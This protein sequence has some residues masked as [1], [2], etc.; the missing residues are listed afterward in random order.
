MNN[1]LASL[2][3]IRKP[4]VVLGTL[5]ATLLVVSPRLAHCQAVDYGA[6]EQLFK[7]PVTTSVTGSPQR[8]SDV[9]ATMV[10]ITAEEIRRSGAKDIPGVLR[11]VGGIDTLEWGN[12]NIDV[13]IR[14]YNQAYSARLLVLLDGRQVYADTYGYVP[15]STIPVELE[16]IRQIEVVK[17]PNSALF[18][19]NAAGGV[20]NIITYDPLRDKV[21]AA[22][23]SGGTQDLGRGSLVTTARFGNR[24]GVRLSVGGRYDSDFSTPIPASMELEPRKQQYRGAIDLNAVIRMN[25]K[26]QLSFEGS[27]SFTQQNEVY[28]GYQ[29]NDVR[30]SISSAKGQ[31]TAENS[32]GLLRVMV[33]TNWLKMIGV[34]GALGQS[35]RPRNRATVV[36]VDEVFQ[37]GPSHTLRV[38]AEYRHNSENTTPFAGGTVYYDDFAGS[39]MWDW[40]IAPR[41]SLT[42]ALRVDHLALGRE[43]LLPP[44]YLFKNSDWNR[45]ITQLTFNSGLVWKV[46]GLDSLRFMIG[47]GAEL[48]SL[49]LN[50]SYVQDTPYVK[51]T[52]SPFLSPAVVTNYEIGWEHLMPR[53]HIQLRWNAF[54]QASASLLAVDGA[55]VVKEGTV[56][57]VPANVGSS[58]GRGFELGMRGAGLK[59][60]RWSVDYRP[61]WITDH[62]VPFSQD[63]P[64]FIDYQHTTPVHLVKGNVGWSNARWELDGYLLYQTQ[65]HGFQAN[66]RGVTLTPIPG[67]LSFDG[68]VAYN[69]TNRITW[70]VSG[71]NLSHSSQ[72]QTSGPAVERRVLGTMTVH[73]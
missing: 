71:Q 73:F 15:W 43:G 38:A 54:D 36:Q 3:R 28:P 51:V 19:F 22:S 30:A 11:H 26:V 34:P 61:E 48:P 67:F 72:I 57:V 42:N 14:G 68:R 20:I 13:S 58:D 53:R 49:V 52:G 12:D 37:T 5:V 27:Q 31:L 4:A 2:I 63:V 33:Y 35:F 41:V 1:A 50:G 39:G 46:G 66:P 64:S 9:P 7:E 17:G 25:D 45:S 69:W 10:I 59:S 23:V 16:A 21:N 6:L 65:M 47:R 44:D 18:G 29:I 55:A 24:A 56:Y 70:S 40:K 62:L 32:I 8:V 60:Y